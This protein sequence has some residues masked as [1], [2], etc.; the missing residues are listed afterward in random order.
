MS[1]AIT[2]ANQSIEQV[3]ALL[4]GHP[5]AIDIPLVHHV[6]EVKNV[7]MR[8]A[9]FPANTFAIG[10]KHTTRHYNIL[11]SGRMRVMNG[12][13]VKEII[14]PAVFIGEPGVRKVAFFVEDTRWLNVMSAEPTT[15]PELEALL[16]EKSETFKEHEALL[17]AQQLSVSTS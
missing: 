16:I 8:E 15:I 6:G 3:E 10:H 14:A 9:F 7:Y 4:L 2:E 13:K 11:L 17:E 1:E 12:D 5:K